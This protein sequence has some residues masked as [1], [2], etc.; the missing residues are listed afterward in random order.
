MQRLRFEMLADRL[1]VVGA[2]E[3]RRP[4][5]RR[6][7]GAI[8]ACALVLSLGVLAGCG[9]EDPQANVSDTETLGPASTEGDIEQSP[10][11]LRESDGYST[12]VSTQ[13]TTR[14][15]DDALVAAQVALPQGTTPELRLKV[16]G[17]VDRDAEVSTAGKG[18]GRFAL[19]SCA[20]KLSTGEHTV[21]LEGTASSGETRVGARTLFVFDEVSFD[22]TGGPAVAQ[23]ALVTDDT[24]VD[25]EGATL[26]QTPAGDGS[27]PSMAIAAIAAPRSRTGMDNVRLAVEIGGDVANELAKTTIP[28]GKLSAYLDNN[29]AG[30]PVVVRGYTT[31]GQV[32]VGTA[33]LIVCNCDIQ[34]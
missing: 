30:E 21:V 19:V 13:V 18:D 14:G 15:K 17:K 11:E 9:E 24:D 31:N 34:R 28:S 3:V 22:D 23:S 4:G 25:A 32:T 16:D 1:G 5:T 20:C 12:L 33:S 29:G 7:A 10:A 2:E 27:G 6:L 8:G 26:A